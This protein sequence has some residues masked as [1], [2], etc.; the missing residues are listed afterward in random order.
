MLPITSLASESAR[1][2]AKTLLQLSVPVR[3]RGVLRVERALP[4]RQTT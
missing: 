3:A 1:W 4:I 2:Q